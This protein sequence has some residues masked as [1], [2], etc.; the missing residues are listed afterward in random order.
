MSGSLIHSSI[1]SIEIQRGLCR[2]S[3]LSVLIA[4]MFDI[5]VIGYFFKVIVLAQCF[6]S[7]LSAVRPGKCVCCLGV[8]LSSFITQLLCSQLVF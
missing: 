7:T 6:P 2:T 1:N 8:N 5:R 4:F 3:V